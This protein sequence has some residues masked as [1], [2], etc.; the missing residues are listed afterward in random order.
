MRF[1]RSYKRH[2]RPL[3]VCVLAL[4]LAQPVSAQSPAPAAALAAAVDVAANAVV[5]SNHVP[6]LAV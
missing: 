5:A 6:G 2:E 4:A 1:E 3:F